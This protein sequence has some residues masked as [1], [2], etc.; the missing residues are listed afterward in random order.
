MGIWKKLIRRASDETPIGATTNAELLASKHPRSALAQ[1]GQSPVPAADS[2]TP[3]TQLH[4]AASSGDAA[5]VESLLNHGAEIDGT[6]TYDNTPLFLAA[7]SGHVAVVKCLLANGASKSI[8]VRMDRG[9]LHG[10]ALKGHTEVIK[11]LLSEGFQVNDKDQLGCTALHSAA[12][13]GH[14]NAVRF[15]LSNGADKNACDNSNATPLHAAA[16]Q[17]HAEIAER[18]LVAGANRG[19]KQTIDGS[20]PIHLAAKDGHVSVLKCLLDHGA[21][22]ASLDVNKRTPLHLAAGHGK[23]PA[24]EYLVSAGA[25]VGAKACQDKTPLDEAIGSIFGGAKAVAEF[26]GK[27]TPRG[28]S[29]VPVKALLPVDSQVQNNPQYTALC[30]KL[31]AMAVLEASTI[32]RN[33]FSPDVMNVAAANIREMRQLGP[34]TIPLLVC[35]L[36]HEDAQ[37][38]ATACHALQTRGHMTALEDDTIEA[39]RQLQ[40]DPDTG[41][42]R[43]AKCSLDALK[44]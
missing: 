5:L 14:L 21:S 35:A 20:Q 17:G 39:M 11:L 19:A 43:Q 10:A 40:S 38:R 15:L 36:R 22:I 18:L 33:P 2:G 12:H 27:R 42:R 3:A 41:V 31:K 9:P 28:A 37:V 13:V 34:D 30:S 29:E 25:D 7:S 26:L 44:R 16:G 4:D 8:R 6:D 32:A 23:L 24:V 1:A